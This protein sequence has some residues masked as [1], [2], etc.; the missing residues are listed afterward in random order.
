MDVAQRTVCNE[1]EGGVSLVRCAT[2]HAV[3]PWPRRRSLQEVDEA[4]QRSRH[5]QADVLLLRVPDDSELQQASSL[6]EL[7]DSVTSLALLNIRYLQA[8]ELN[9]RAFFMALNSP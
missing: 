7:N 6:E 8:E 2:P 5:R 4:F 9:E 3:W 1:L